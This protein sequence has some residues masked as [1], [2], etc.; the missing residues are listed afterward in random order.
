MRHPVVLAALLAVAA[1]GGSPSA[2]SPPPPPPAPPVPQTWTLGGPLTDA[3]TRAP[4]GGATVSVAG[5]EPA[6]TNDAGLWQIQGTGFP[7]AP[8]ATTITAP[9]YITRETRVTWRA[10]GRQDAALDLVPERPPFSLEFYRQFVRNAY[11]TPE[12]LEPLRRWTANPNFY[13]NTLNPRTGLPIEPS[14]LNDIM[15]AL[16]DAVPQVTG[17]ILSVGTIE[18]APARRPRR[19]GYINIEIVYEPDGGFCG[20]SFVGIDPG[21]ITLNYDG[22]PSCG[23]R[24]LPPSVVAHEVGHAL[25]F[26]HVP[27]GRMS[28]FIDGCGGTGFSD[29]ERLHARIAYSRPP[30]NLD[31][32]RDPDDYAALA[33]GTSPR[34]ECPAP[35]RA[36]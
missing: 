7:F 32:D 17:G 5:Y 16:H 12:T 20:R 14:A 13:V 33:V 19:S 29:D 8:L 9:G 1:C 2:P 23:S 22:C 30:G 18:A 10:G 4:V 15:R 21:E 27:R 6:A 3:V 31:P 26:W 34:V 28:R 24:K 36:R 25:G 35:A 11:E